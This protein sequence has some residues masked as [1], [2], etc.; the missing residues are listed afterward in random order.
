[1]PGA[2]WKPESFNTLR[3]K[4]CD[5]PWQQGVTRGRPPA[6]TKPPG[7]RSGVGKRPSPA[8]RVAWGSRELHFPLGCGDAGSH[9]AY[10]V[11]TLSGQPKEQD[12]Q[13]PKPREAKTRALVTGRSPSTKGSSGHSKRCPSC[14]Y[15]TLPC[16]HRQVPLPRA[17]FSCPL[18]STDAAPRLAVPRAASFL[19]FSSSCQDRKRS[20]SLRS[21]N[22]AP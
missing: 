12:G 7:Q 5:T 8:Y 6:G 15:V 1:M 4:R 9:P 20:L 13:R 19:F 14:S 18:F 3:S 22:S 11:A 17:P 21:A 2:A 10:R 16:A